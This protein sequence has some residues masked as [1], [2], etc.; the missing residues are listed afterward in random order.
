MNIRNIAV[1]MDKLNSRISALEEQ[2]QE[3]REIIFMLVE[4][5]ELVQDDKDTHVSTL[6]RKGVKMP[7]L[8]QEKAP[9]QR[10]VEDLLAEAQ[11][12]NE[13]PPR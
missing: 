8:R 4:K 7:E 9:P 6:K 3:L 10:S 11:G 5:S 2:I 12:L 13:K 1:S